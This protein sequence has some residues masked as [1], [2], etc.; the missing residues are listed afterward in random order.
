MVVAAISR[1]LK[2]TAVTIATMIA[3]MFP[4]WL[5]KPSMKPFSVV[6]FVS[7]CELANMF[8]EGRRQFERPRRVRD[9]D[10]MPPDQPCPALPVLVE[11]V[12]SEEQL[13]LVDALAAVVDADDVELPGACPVSL[14]DRRLDRD[15]V[16]D[17]QP[18]RSA[19]S[20][21]RSR[22][23]GRQPRRALLGRQG[24]LRVQVEVRLRFDDD[25]RE[26][27]RRVLVDAAEPRL[28]RGQLA[29]RPPAEAEPGRFPAAA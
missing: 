29:R 13:R 22:P 20:R 1:M 7:A 6:V 14:P 28:V 4:T 16:A 8:V 21:R 27:V 24:E 9:A 19:R 3:P 12:V 17:R 23:G 15:A 2:S 5:A 18:K 11:I 25:L 26:E 10:D